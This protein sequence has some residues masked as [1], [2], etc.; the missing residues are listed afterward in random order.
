M[1]LE[2]GAYPEAPR[3]VRDE[4]RLTL[5]EWQMPD[6]YLAARLVSTELV[7]NAV[8]ATA[9]IDGHLRDGRVVPGRPPIRFWLRGDGEQLLVQVW[10]AS[11]RMPVLRQTTELDERGRGLVIVDQ[12][13][14][15]WGAYLPDNDRTNSGKF[16][17]AQITSACLA[18]LVGGRLLLVRREHD[19]RSARLLKHRDPVV[20]V[21]EHLLAA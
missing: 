18:V 2:L 1:K 16:V 11:P 4:I 20:A 17:F 8:Q 9:G 5:N 15:R 3:V 19:V 10:D 7:N 14:E 12:L 21:A 6:F 13:S